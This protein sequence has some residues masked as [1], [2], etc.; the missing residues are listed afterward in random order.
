MIRGTPILSAA[1]KLAVLT[2][3]IGILHH[4]DHV[5]RYDHSGWP[6]TPEVNTFTY[7][8]VVYPVIAIVLAAREW[9][10]LRVRLALLLF[11]FPTA[12]HI[13]IETPLDQYSTWC[14]PGV[15]LLEADSPALGVAAGTITVMLSV[16]AFATFVAYLRASRREAKGIS[17]SCPPAV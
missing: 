17:A 3:A 4:V 8:L 10:L 9:P 5:L 15:N 14:S 11:L 12:A 6:F 7:S 13:F 2:A 16:S 1:D